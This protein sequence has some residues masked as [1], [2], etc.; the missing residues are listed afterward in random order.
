MLAKDP[1]ERFNANKIDEYLKIN[2]KI[3]NIFLIL[4]SAN[5]RTNGEGK[6]EDTNS[7]YN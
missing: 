6:R 5:Y 7:L 3:E 4:T 2:F 1:K